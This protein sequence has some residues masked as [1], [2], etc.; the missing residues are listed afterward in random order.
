MARR[1]VPARGGEP[2]PDPDDVVLLV[3]EDG[4]PGGDAYELF[5]PDDPADGAR[6]QSDEYLAG[7][8]DRRPGVTLALTLAGERVRRAA[9]RHPVLTGIAALC[10]VALVL[11]VAAYAARPRPSSFD[12]RVTAGGYRLN[13]TDGVLSTLT[14]RNP[15]GGPVTLG[16]V[17]IGGLGGRDIGTGDSSVD[18]PI[19]AG[20]TGE[21]V[22]RGMLDCRADQPAVP[23]TAE[24]TGTDSRGLSRTVSV[25]LPG[26]AAFSA[27]IDAYRT[28]ICRVPYPLGVTTISYGGLERAETQP[29]YALAM[30][31]DVAV[32]TVPGMDPTPVKFATVLSNLPGVRA[33]MSAADPVTV[34]P[35]SPG[36][37]DVLWVVDDCSRIPA[38]AG[39]LAVSVMGVD[40]RG[41][42][43][44]DYAL[45]DR[46][47]RDLLDG[48]ATFCRGQGDK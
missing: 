33:M 20:G 39:I 43:I 13:G 42:Q 29:G 7:T 47:S 9:R 34:A 32:T 21:V 2:F 14:V 12:A 5:D 22:V 36:R 35:G 4:D 31:L 41:T 28:G 44:W 18:M 37:I 23:P 6:V 48:I 3:P 17:V 46:F 16:D 19:P 1:N 25:A 8:G 15:T 24:L 38:Y 45:G 11:G 40:R 30:R 27:Q 26:S 10:A